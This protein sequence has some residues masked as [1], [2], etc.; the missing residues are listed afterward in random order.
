MASGVCCVAVAL[1]G[2]TGAPLASLSL[3]TDPEHSLDRLVGAV[4]QTE[5]ILSAALRGR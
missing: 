5:R 4:Q 3:V 1:R 2:P